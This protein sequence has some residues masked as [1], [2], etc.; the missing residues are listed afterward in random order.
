MGGLR[1]NGDPLEDKNEGKESLCVAD[2]F[3]NH[4]RHSGYAFATD[5][6]RMEPR[7]V[8][9]RTTPYQCIG[10]E[11]VISIRALLK[12]PVLMQKSRL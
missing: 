5:A 8:A 12:K 3:R 6:R 2:P 9:L 7:T 4:V 1:I 11:F 10:G